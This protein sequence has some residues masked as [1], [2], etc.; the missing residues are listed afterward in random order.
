MLGTTPLVGRTFI[1]EESQPGGAPVAVVSYGLWQRILG[2]KSDLTGTSLRISDKSFTVVG[3][4]PPGFDFPQNAEVW[5]P[6]EGSV[7]EISRSA[8]NWQVVARL[9]PAIVDRTSAGRS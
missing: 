3:V 8:H 5:V 4:M 9:A 7:A 1:K 2:G 6:R